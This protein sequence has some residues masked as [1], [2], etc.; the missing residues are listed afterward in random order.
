MTEKIAELNNDMIES[1]LKLR[2]D[3]EKFCTI[4]YF[5]KKYDDCV[6]FGEF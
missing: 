1:N 4:E 2:K 5:N 3:S 6:L